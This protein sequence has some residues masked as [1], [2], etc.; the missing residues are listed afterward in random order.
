[1]NRVFLAFAG[2]FLDVLSNNRIGHL[3]L[4]SL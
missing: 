3:D 4:E 2:L 1:M